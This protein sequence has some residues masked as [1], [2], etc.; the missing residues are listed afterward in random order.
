MRGKTAALRQ[1]RWQNGLET[2]AA[3]REAEA[4]L[5]M[6]QGSLLALDEQLALQR[7][8]IR[9][10]CL[11]PD[12]TAAWLSP[13]RRSRRSRPS[14][15]RRSWRLNCWGAVPTSPPHG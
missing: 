5:A 7:N 15:C 2:R 4:R 3:V 9:W 8:T 14:D 1:E 11:A 10:P 12:P 6:V 13:R